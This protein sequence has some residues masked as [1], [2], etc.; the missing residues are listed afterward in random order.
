MLV[1]MHED[2]SH[3]YIVA[4]NSSNADKSLFV[5]MKN[6]RTAEAV[7]RARDGEVLKVGKP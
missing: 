2:N 5:K 3:Y 4:V 1:R 7:V 6:G